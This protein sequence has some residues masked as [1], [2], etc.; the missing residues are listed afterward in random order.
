MRIKRLNGW[1]T[2]ANAIEVEKI[3]KM[4]DHGYKS[5]ICNRHD[6]EE[7]GQV[8]FAEV[9][10]E[11]RL[12]GIECKHIPVRTE[13]S[14]VADHNLF[15]AAMKNMPGPIMA[16]CKSGKRC[17]ELWEAFD[18]RRAANGEERRSSQPNAAF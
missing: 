13:G 2:I 17:A 9:V 3:Q 6:G 11:A 18:A 15:T 14:T 7:N 16:Y 4:A 8:T 1:I 5:I 10:A 12:F